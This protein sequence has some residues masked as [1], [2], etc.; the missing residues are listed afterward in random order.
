MICGKD[1]SA[2]TGIGEIL[3]I[4]R[5]GQK[6]DGICPAF[7]EGTDTVDQQPRVTLNLR[8][9]TL[10]QFTQCQ[11]HAIR[12]LSVSVTVFLQPRQHGICDIDAGTG[13]HHAF[14][15][16]QVVIIGLG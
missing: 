15:D 13:E 7:L 9:G 3:P 14:T 6:T 12:R 16:D 4:L 1:D 5:I 8:P 10:C 2:R 11:T